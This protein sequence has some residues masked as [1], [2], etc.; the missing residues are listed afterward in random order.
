MLIIVQTYI[1][2][3]RRKRLEI[4]PG[5]DIRTYL[6]NDSMFVPAYSLPYT[7]DSKTNEPVFLEE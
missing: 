7:W 6:V 3:L 4:K 2:N 5:E 1:R